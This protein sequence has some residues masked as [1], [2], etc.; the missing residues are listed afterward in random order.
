[1][2]ATEAVWCLVQWLNTPVMLACC[3]IDW[4]TKLAHLL[5]SKKEEEP[6]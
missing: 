2:I 1:M 5:N 4:D 3:R 6:L